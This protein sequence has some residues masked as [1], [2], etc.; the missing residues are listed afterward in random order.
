MSLRLSIKHRSAA[1]TL[2]ELLVVIAII[3]I[4]AGML[5]PALARARGRA[6]A[7]AC[8]SKLKQ[9][10]MGCAMYASDNQDYLP[11]T[12]H[13]GA[14]WIGTLATYG[15]T[16]VYRCPVDTNRLRI[17]S[18]GIN[19]FLT[20]HPYGAADVDFTKTTF[21]PSASDTIHL[22][23]A[24]ENFVGS[25]HFHFADAAGGGFGT[26]SFPLQV[27]VQRHAGSANYL[28]AEGHVEG[29][30]WSR[31]RN[32]LGPPATRFVRPDGRDPNQKP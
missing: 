6:Q 20:P 23:E 31:V 17:T 14:S 2:V 10:G 1:F 30:R 13:Q 8:M 5:L 12:S 27:A 22:A 11:Q 18:Y 26:N 29:L 16:N 28:F 25:D 7:L 9:L 15:L 24:R 19:D 3:A 21:L 32:L 4:L